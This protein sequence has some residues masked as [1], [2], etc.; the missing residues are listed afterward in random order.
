MSAEFITLVLGIL[1]L[2]GGQIATALILVGRMDRQADQT[3]KRFDGFS[4]GVNQRFDGVN[5]RFDDM[6][7][8]F[9]DLRERMARLEGVME[10]FVAGRRDR[11]VA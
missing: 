9:A 6:S 10:G 5:Q 2:A 1:T 3:N 11:G 4:D 7:R 8:E